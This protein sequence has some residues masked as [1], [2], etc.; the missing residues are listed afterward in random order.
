MAGRVPEAVLAEIRARLPIDVLV[1]R[2]V[3]LKRN[4]RWH[5]GLCPFH[6]ER[7]PSF[8]VRSDSGTFHCFG[9]G[10]H[11]D[12]FAWTM[13]R[14]GCDF[15]AAVLRC[16]AEAGVPV[17][18]DAPAPAPWRAPE[19]AA[20]APVVDRVADGRERADI[21]GRIWSRAAPIAADGPVAAY[22]RGRALW[23]LPAPAH[24]VLRQARLR[25][26]D[27]GDALHW[28]MVARVDGPL[29]LLRGVHRTYLA[30]RPGGWGK[31]AGVEAR[32]ALGSLPG[33]AIRLLPAEGCLGL[34]EGIETALAAHALT[35]LPVWACISASL[36]ELVEPPFDVGRIVV[37]ADR[38]APRPDKGM[39]D[40]HGIF[41]ARRLAQR[42][43]AMAR[44][45][46][47]R[48]PFPPAK[49]YADVW[50]A[51]QIAPLPQIR[52][53]EGLMPAPAGSR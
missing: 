25:H 7:T 42:Q 43:R 24:Q 22:L 37:F 8:T 53:G 28:C 31:I 14:E 44:E 21:A 10:A 1:S 5:T 18:L 45:T 34:A 9:C 4:G 49:D 38:D 16:A 11:G 19:R 50:A 36:M 13:R 23:P 40:G 32:L 2:A 6:Q 51:R 47:I 17:D 33:A 20:A 39:P 29:G 41:A 30:E 15:R 52:N 46:E 12:I 35:G 26:K 3:V 27:T 48:T